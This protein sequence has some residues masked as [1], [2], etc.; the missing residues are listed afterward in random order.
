MQLLQ[1]I[2]NICYLFYGQ[3]SLL[4]FLLLIQSGKSIYDTHDLDLFFGIY[5]TMKKDDQRQTHYF[6]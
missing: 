1:C 5:N 4:L 3:D 2:G 6:S